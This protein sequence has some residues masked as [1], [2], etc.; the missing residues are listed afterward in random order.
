MLALVHYP[1]E[2][3]FNSTQNY[4]PL[5][6]TVSSSFYYSRKEERQRIRA[7]SRTSSTIR[8]EPQEQQRIRPA[9]RTFYLLPPTAPDSLHS[10]IFYDCAR[11]TRN[12]EN[13]AGDRN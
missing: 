4:L 13:I 8:F 3:I 6:S 12:V 1:R 9:D 5:Q 11:V 10:D 7:L 2:T